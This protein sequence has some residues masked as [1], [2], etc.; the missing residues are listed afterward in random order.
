MSTH[1]GNSVTSLNVV[2]FALQEF[3]KKKR[4]E[5]GKKMYLKKIIAKIPQSGEKQNQQKQIYTKTYY[6]QNGKT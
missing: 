4:A 6:N 3:Q 1:L 2:T 5:K